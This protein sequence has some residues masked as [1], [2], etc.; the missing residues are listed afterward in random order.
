MSAFEMIPCPCGGQPHKIREN[1]TWLVRCKSCHDS[2]QETVAE[3]VADWNRRMKGFG[4]GDVMAFINGRMKML[5]VAKDVYDKAGLMDGY[6]LSI[7]YLDECENI[8]SGLSTRFNNH[9]PTPEAGSPIV[10]LTSE[11][12]A[13]GEGG[14][15][16]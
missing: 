3:A 4:L 5:L 9:S 1:D 13:R 16:L 12:G 10:A 2:G 6:Y 14:G 7:A 11:G 8:K 15:V